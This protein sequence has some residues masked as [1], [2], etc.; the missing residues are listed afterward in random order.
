M[1]REMCQF[2]IF[3]LIL[4]LLVTGVAADGHI[5]STLTVEYEYFG[6]QP[7]ILTEQGKLKG[8][9]FMISKLYYGL[10]R[11]KMEHGRGVQFITSR[12]ICK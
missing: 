1:K 9:Y 11:K 12:L 4:T 10:K 8:K 5:G 6:F 7:P 2:F 3:L